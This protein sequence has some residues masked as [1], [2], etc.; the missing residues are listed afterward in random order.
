VRR[1]PLLDRVLLA[2]LT[3]IWFLAVALHVDRQ[4]GDV[5]L[6]WVPLYVEPA[7]APDQHPIATGWWPETPAEH[8]VLAPGDRVL[9]A[10][11]TDLRGAGHFATWAR[12]LA[13]AQPDLGVPVVGE[14]DGRRFEARLQ[15]R[16][17]PYP[18]R[19]LPLAL[20]LGLSALLAL[21]RGRGAPAVRAYALGALSYSLQ[22]SFLFGE[23]AWRTVLGLGLFFAAG[24]FYQPFTLRA[25]LLFPESVAVRSRAAHLSCWVFAVTAFGLWV[26]LFGAP[27]SGHT[28]L[29]IL[30]ASY[31]GWIV[32]FLGILAYNYRRADGRG[33]RQLL[34]V[35][36]GFYVGLGPAIAGSV[37]FG[38]RPDLRMVY[39]LSLLPTVLIPL[40]LYVAFLRYQLFD[41]ARL[42]TTTV[43]ITLIAPAFL[44]AVLTVAPLVADWASRELGLHRGT[45]L[46]VLA[47]A[48]AAPGVW[49]AQWLR[50]RIE[51]LL[52][53]DRFRLERGLR[54]LRGEIRGLPDA[55][56]LFRLLGERL[57]AL[58]DLESLVIYARAGAGYA[59][60]HAAGPIVPPGFAAGSG[61]TALLADGTAPVDAERM[62]RWMRSGSIAA[63]DRA[64][65]EAL[66]VEAIVP[67]H[68]ADALDAFVCLGDKRSGDVF[69]RAELALLEGVAERA[70]A[71][72]ERHDEDQL[73]AEQ[74]AL[75]ESL[76]SY[77]P[78]AVREELVRGADLEPGEREVTVLFVDIRGYT[79]FSAQRG[80]SEIFRVVNAYTTA[81]SRVIRE[82]GGSVV[83]FH[84]DGIMAAF[85]APQELPDKERAAVE[86]ARA[87]VKVV[88]G[89]M[90]GDLGDVHLSV[91]VG[92][93]TGPAYVGNLQSIDRKIW[94]VIGNTT[95]LASRLEGLTRTLDASIAIDAP[96]RARAGSSAADFEEHAGVRVKGRDEALSVFAIRRGVLA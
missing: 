61:F 76:A 74:R 4:L 88:D 38:L 22:W 80:A 68:R 6:A 57:G 2:V 50:P 41:I 91:G 34:W 7:R 65:L 18:W 1:L 55:A 53:R 64:S 71:E 70:S 11:G 58:L 40:C 49:V 62:R 33:R 77:A 9:Q 26:W 94:G 54:E 79:G 93:A 75:Y 95:N 37:V 8:Q 67:L 5:P 81:V 56:A 84:G 42:V 59:P 90:L 32:L 30:S 45:S 35:V 78:E 15:L 25:A 39:E 29:R 69:T 51:R 96:T 17:M 20:A 92:I 87:A 14:R 63:V 46:W 23:E 24:A 89:G 60:V 66:A 3:P 28:G 16:P 73:L 43:A 19:T 86:A 72:L 48:I 85:G 52:F 10:G 21:L 44:G 13:A 31:L 27:L 12:L 47:F 83:E 36:F 82:H